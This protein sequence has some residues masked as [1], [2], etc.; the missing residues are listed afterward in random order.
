MLQARV[1]LPA[2]W[3]QCTVGYVAG[4]NPAA[5]PPSGSNVGYD[6]GPGPAAHPL[7]HICPHGPPHRPL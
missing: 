2:L 3:L 6:A 1:L 7:V 4:P 5:C